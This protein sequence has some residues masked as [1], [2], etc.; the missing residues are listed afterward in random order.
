[1]LKEKFDLTGKIAPTGAT[2][3]IDGGL[4]IPG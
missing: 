3:L 1:M 2:I 4:S